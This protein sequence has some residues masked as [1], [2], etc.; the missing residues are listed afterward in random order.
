MSYT[1]LVFDVKFLSEEQQGIA[2]FRLTIPEFP[3]EGWIIK[4]NGS[5]YEVH[6]IEQIDYTEQ[7]AIIFLK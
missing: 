1:P 4:I 7:T 3:K 5:R 6:S 2:K